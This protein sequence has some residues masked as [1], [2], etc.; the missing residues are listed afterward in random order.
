MAQFKISEKRLKEIIQEGIMEALE[1]EGLGS[2]LGTA[3]Q[4][5]RN[6]FNNFKA[7]YRAAQNIQRL[8]NAPYD[9]F[10][11]YGEEGERARNMNGPEYSAYRYNQAVERN[12]QAPQYT[13]EKYGKST[14]QN[15]STPQAQ[16]QSQPTPQR[17]KRGQSIKPQHGHV[18]VSKIA[19]NPDL[20]AP[21][22]RQQNSV[23]QKF[24]VDNSIKNDTNLVRR[25]QN[26]TDILKSQYNLSPIYSKNDLVNGNPKKG[27]TPVN[28]KSANGGKLTPQQRQAI[29]QWAKFKL[30]EQRENVDKILQEI[31]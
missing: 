27:A 12:K 30:R 1:D 19:P 31:L 13:R 25:A 10:A 14:P 21:N 8:R 22:S 20:V 29:Q 7:D 17:Q 5:V 9:A 15:N 16:D 26:V 6:K 28:W 24:N 11:K 18:D 4:W 2:M 3:T 23:Q